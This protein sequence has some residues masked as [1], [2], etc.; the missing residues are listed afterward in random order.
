[1]NSKIGAFLD[2]GLAKDLLLPFAEQLG[3]VR[4]GH[5]VLVFIKIDRKSKRILATMKTHSHL[6]KSRPDYE[7][8]EAVSLLVAEETPMGSNAFV[9]HRHLGLIHHS[10]LASPLTIGQNLDGFVA[11]IRPDGKIDLSLDQA[12]YERVGSLSEDIL[13]ALRCDP[14]G[15]L[16]MGDKTAPKDIRRTFGVSKKAFKQALGALYKQKKIR[17]VG[18]GVQL[19]E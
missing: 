9:N 19:T 13:E 11:D 3:R 17:F 10:Q 8:G 16:E 4:E 5:R 18:I 1:V 7:K 15:F 14:K 6:E 2:W 12:G